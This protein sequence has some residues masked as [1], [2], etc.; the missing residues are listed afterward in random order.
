MAINR[1]GKSTHV[2]E[3]KRTWDRTGC[4]NDI[5]RL[6]GLIH[7]CAKQVNGSLEYGMLGLLIVET[8]STAYEVKTQ[9]REKAESIDDDIRRSFGLKKSKAK[10]SLGRMRRYP[11]HYG[12]EEEWA[13]T[14]FCIA[15]SA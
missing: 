13:A 11:E 15:L 2:I 14:G 4:F 12:E 10:Y 9:T 5:E 6:L 1:Q 3:V 7:T 8:G